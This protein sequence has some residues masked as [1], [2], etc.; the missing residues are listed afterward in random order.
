[1]SNLQ[2]NGILYLILA[3]VSHGWAR[4]TAGLMS[5]FYIIAYLISSEDKK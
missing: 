5:I 3:Q 4:L 2:T 1:M